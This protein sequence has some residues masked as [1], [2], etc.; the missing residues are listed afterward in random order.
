M[1]SASL[2]GRKKIVSYWKGVDNMDELEA[3]IEKLNK[4]EKECRELLKELKE[5]LKSKLEE[6][7]LH[8]D[9]KGRLRQALLEEDWEELTKAIREFKKKYG[10]ILV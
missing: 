1:K 2:Y 8:P 3:K 9:I 5:L 10:K 7:I 4:L 6:S